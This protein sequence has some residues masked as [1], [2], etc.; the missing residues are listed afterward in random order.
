MTTAPQV[1]RVY[2]NSGYFRIF[3]Y[4][5]NGQKQEITTVRGIPTLITSM[6]TAD[7]FG[8]SSASLSFAGVT[9][10]DKPGIGNP[11]NTKQ[12]NEL[13]WLVP[14]AKITIRWYDMTDSEDPAK[15]V[16]YNDWVWEG[17]IASEEI[18][19]PYVV[20]CKGALYQADNFMAKPFFPNQPVPYEYMMS[21]LLNPDTHPTIGT[22]K[23]QIEWPS[24]WA[25]F[26]PQHRSPAYLSFLNPFGVSVGAKWSGLTTRDT[27]SWQ[28][29]L[30]G[31]IQ[32]LLTTMFTNQGDQW[33]V[34]KKIGRTPVLRVRKT[35]TYTDTNTLVIYNGTPGVKTSFSR[36]FTQTGNVV[37]GAGTGLNGA[38]FSGMQ[39]G[40][41]G[42]TTWYEP[43][44]ALPQSYP[45][46]PVSNTKYLP[47]IAVKE[48]RISFPQGMDELSAKDNALA[49][50]TRMAD[51][52]YTGTITMQ[53]DPMRGPKPF[54]KFLIQAGQT[55]LLRNFRGTD[56][57]FHITQVEIAPEE[58]SV[59]VTVDTKYR[60]ALT[61]GEVRARTRD[62]LNPINLLKPG[63][64]QLTVNDLVKPW[65]SAHGSGII[66]PDATSFF[67]SIPATEEF[68]W[69]NWV[70]KHPPSGTTAKY[71]IK[72][73]AKGTKKL[74][75]QMWQDNGWNG[76]RSLG[77]PIKGAQQAN[78]RLIQIAAF[79]KNGNPL[80]IPFHVSL[81]YTSGVSSDAMPSI[82]DNSPL[83]GGKTYKKGEHY[84]F[85]PQAFNKQKPNGEI[86][87]DSGVMLPTDTTMING[88]GTYQEP[89]GYSPGS[90]GAGGQLTGMLIDE[91]TWSFDTT[92]SESTFDA[93][94]IA[95]TSK[96]KTAGMIYAMFYQDA[97]AEAYFIG[98]FYR[99]LSGSTSGG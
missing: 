1:F 7:P 40:R 50:L 83:L 90:K 81:Y 31:Y 85:F 87:S 23:L 27:G 63:S 75:N 51:P 2:G 8:D 55:I 97:V 67:S 65:D 47:S 91:S 19:Q 76:T 20:Q 38:S 4:H 29:I 95:N 11:A 84:P 44:A 64:V 96:I 86:T 93:E 59:T 28:P 16:M 22:N 45:Y 61:V 52:G 26:V 54:N 25:T 92:S 78:I 12:R 34:M 24:D 88:W 3:A 36:D 72:V 39:V 6:S 94:S 18:D 56:V 9:S 60:D 62:S 53:V 57:L 30:T 80:K 43:F 77:V 13:W 14:Y 74:A 73:S 58:N 82:T 35:V 69:L 41:D 46:P 71:Y 17:Y 89:A 99:V 68:P 98:R 48:S 21:L 10:F 37:Y 49:Q 70:K 32:G 15:A 42:E 79:D 5:P 33:T 66:P